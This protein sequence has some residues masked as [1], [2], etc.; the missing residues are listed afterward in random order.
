MKKTTARIEKR[1]V[2]INHKYGIHA[3][4]AAKIVALS[5]TFK[6]DIEVVKDGEQPANAKNILDIMMLAAANGVTLELRVKGD[7]AHEAME[8]LAA[9]L[10]SDFD[11][12]EI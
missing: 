6:S 12:R 2:T 9:L 4:P 1:K 7:D 5:N 11:T 8:K 3:R 10:E